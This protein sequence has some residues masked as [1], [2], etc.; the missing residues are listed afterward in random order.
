M[1]TQIFVDR[2]CQVK[3]F[4]RVTM[5][6]GVASLDDGYVPCCLSQLRIE[7]ETSYVN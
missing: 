1:Q 6:N 5:T 4:D 7:G 2:K 3:I